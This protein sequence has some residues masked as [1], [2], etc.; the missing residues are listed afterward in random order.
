[1]PG[2]D[3]LLTFGDQLSDDMILKLTKSV[4][5]SEETI[6]E[7]L[8]KVLK[9]VDVKGGK[10]LKTNSAKEFLLSLDIRVNDVLKKTRYGDAVMD[11]VYDFDKIEKNSLD[12][13]KLI[14]GEKISPSVVSKI[15]QLEVESTIDKLL[16]S[17]VNNSFT[18]PVR[19]ALYRNIA[20]GHGI[21]DAEATIEAFVRSTPDADSKLLR[22][23]KQ[24][25]RDSIQQYD[26]SIQEKIGQH[27][28]TNGLVYT[29]SLVADSRPQCIRWVKKRE[30]CNDDLQKEIDWAYNNGSG[31]IPSTTP[32]NFKTN[33]GGYHCRHRA[34]AAKVKCK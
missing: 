29:G 28:G 15:S 23:V 19:E 14:N 27:L 7:E 12:I 31:M 32:E 3:T 18:I 10:L 1:M 20:L 34:F 21:K 25:S 16:V 33:R 9:K 4:K 30:I 5:K 26:G 8:M 11:F 22:Y 6:F 17:G 24:V 2:I 13:S